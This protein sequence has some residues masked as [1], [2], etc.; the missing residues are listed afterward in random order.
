MGDGRC[1]VCT[2]TPED[3]EEIV[4]GACHGQVVAELTARVATL[5]SKLGRLAFYIRPLP[6]SAADIMREILDAPQ[7]GG[8]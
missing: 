4:C 1:E 2:F 6:G 5:E 3:G 8:K 7:G